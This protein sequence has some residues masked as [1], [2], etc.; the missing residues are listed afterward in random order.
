[1]NSLSL[2]LAVISGEQD[3]GVLPA[4][5]LSSLNR[6]IL[7]SSCETSLIE[8]LIAWR[9]QPLKSSDNSNIIINNNNTYINNNRI[10]IKQ[11]QWLTNDS[12]VHC[13]KVTWHRNIH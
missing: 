5:L 10:I 8:R 3:I 2:S 1:M 11:Q 9:M 4:S 6:A 13:Y 7:P 12:I